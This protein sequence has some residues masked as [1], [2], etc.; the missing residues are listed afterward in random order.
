MNKSTLGQQLH[1]NSF[2]FDWAIRVV[3]LPG[4]LDCVYYGRLF[5]RLAFGMGFVYIGQRF[6]F[7]QGL[8]M[9]LSRSMMQNGLKSNR[10]RAGPLT[11]PVSQETRE[12]SHNILK[13]QKLLIN[14]QPQSINSLGPKHWIYPANAN[15]VW[16]SNLARN[17]CKY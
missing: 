15:F 12:L 5:V 17:F 11:Q 3:P 8:G 14:S 6:K 2:S 16:I 7:C 9:E 4:Q 10:F 1:L 13:N